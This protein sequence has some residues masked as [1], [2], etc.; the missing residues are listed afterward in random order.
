MTTPTNSLRGDLRRTP[1]LLLILVATSVTPLAAAAPPPPGASGASGQLDSYDARITDDDRSHW[2]FQPVHRPPLPEVAN[3]WWCRNPID[4][5]VLGRLEANGVTPA[6]PAG[7]RA[8]M[9]RLFLDVTGLPPTP[10][11]QEAFLHADGTT[12]D[13]VER[14]VD[15]LLN[16]PAYGERWGRRWLDLVRY[17]E[18]NGYERDATKP[19]A[20]RYRDYVIRNLNADKPFDRFVVEQLAGDELPAGEITAETLVA[21]GFFRL[22]PWDDEPADPRQDRSDQLDDLVATTSQVFLGLTLACARCHN[23]KFEPL[24]MHDYYRMVAVFDPLQ[25]PRKGRTERAL[26]IGNAESLTAQSRRDAQIA[27]LE[28]ELASARKAI[29]SVRDRDQQQPE[30][31][32]RI[33][34]LEQSIERLRRESPELPLG[35]FLHEPSPVPPETH[36]LLRGQAINPGPVVG[37]GVP[38]VLVAAQPAFP[39]EAAS[40]VSTSRRRLALAHWLT[41]PGNPLT[42]RVIVNRVWQGHFGVGLVRTPSDF[43]VMGEPPTHPELLDWL[44]SWFVAEGWS[45]KKLH[46]LILTSATYRMSTRNSPGSAANDPENPLL[47]RRP[48][49]RLEVEV[50]CDAML[51]ASGELNREMYGPSMYPFIPPEALLG[52]SDPDKV[53]KPSN[54]VAASRRSIYAFLKRSLVVPL[55]ELLDLCDTARSAATRSVTS[56]PTQALTQLNGDF[57]NRQARH[58]AERLRREAGPAPEDQLERAFLLTMA[59]PPT[60]V[61]RTAMLGYLESEATERLAEARMEDRIEDT[62]RARHEALVECCR[63]ILNANEFVYPD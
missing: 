44:A 56:V 2:A 43:G 58:L 63:A 27:P 9:R 6:P 8:L 33:R 18:T 1:L 29:A 38:A 37:P 47:A 39:A 17:A 14:L 42:A 61:E 15:D 22:G 26:P 34:E 32:R 24:T 50:I 62:A 13:A 23:H 7:T 53:W 19:F 59:R 40:G 4:R 35:Y 55:F 31:L 49:R 57:V 54:E 21:T 25:R 28:E 60:D 45:L 51:A 10:E 52:H 11:E 48:Y 5:F 36:L 16:R 46:R 41:T 12:P 20:W 3:R 30:N